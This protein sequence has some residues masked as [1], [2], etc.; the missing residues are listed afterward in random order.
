MREWIW[1][2]RAVAFPLAAL[3]AIAT[4]LLIFRANGTPLQMSAFLA[5]FN[6]LWWLGPLYLYLRRDQTR[7]RALEKQ[8]TLVYLRYPGSRPGSLQDRWA[9][10]VAASRPGKILFQEVMSGTDVTLGLPTEIEILDRAGPP[11]SVT[12][13]MA[14]QLPPGLKAQT[15]TMAHGMVEVAA[16]PSALAALEHHVLRGD[17]TES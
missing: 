3:L 17:P 15:F 7:K 10:G 4:P 16:E 13:D 8:G 11:R 6:G 2:H 5:L 14:R 9:G 1:R 12:H